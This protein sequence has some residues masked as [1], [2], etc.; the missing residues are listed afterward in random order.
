MRETV[1]SITLYLILAGTLGVLS[2]LGVALDPESYWL[3]RVIAVCGLGVAVAFIVTGARFKHSVAVR[4]PVP[5]RVLLGAAGYSLL[6][7]LLIIA[8]HA[9]SGTPL[10]ANQE[11]VG[12]I[13][14]S[15]FG[16]LITWYLWSSVRRIMSAPIESAAA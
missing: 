12:Q 4:S 2:Q 6:V 5:Q 14:R 8:L 1:R 10:S 9:V 13:G 11:G 7:S 3:D 16:L 15:V